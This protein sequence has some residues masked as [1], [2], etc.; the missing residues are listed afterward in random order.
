MNGR[1]VTVHSFT[2][3]AQVQMTPA[4]VEA[5]S[6]TSPDGLGVGAELMLDLGTWDGQPI[7][8]SAQ[9]LRD[10]IAIGGAT[11]TAGYTLVLADVG[12]D[13]SVTVTATNLFGAT[14]TTSATV[15]P[16]TA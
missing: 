7:T 8:Y 6:I 11:S 14:S 2:G 9:W 16:I 5:P 3:V 12:T 13:I 15:G 4:V 1:I 10:G